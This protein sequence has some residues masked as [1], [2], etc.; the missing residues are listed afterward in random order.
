MTRH[1]DR[2][3]IAVIRHSDRAECIGL[4]HCA[5]Y[6]GVG[7]RFSVRNRQQRLPASELKISAA[8]IERKLESAAIAGKIFLQ[9]AN[10]SPQFLPVIFEYESRIFLAQIARIWAYR[11]LAGQARIEFERHQPRCGCR[12]EQRSHRRFDHSTCEFFLCRW[13]FSDSHNEPT[14]LQTV[15]AGEK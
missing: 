13:H 15:P 4:T 8:E 11:L 10:V 5:C 12:Q 6:I 3:R 1:D 7:S 2:N 9:F 14:L